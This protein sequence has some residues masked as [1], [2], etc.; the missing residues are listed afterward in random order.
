MRT[1]P[2]EIFPA[3]D[4]RAGRAVRLRQGDSKRETRY[5]EDPVSVACEFEQAGARALHVVDLDGAFAG[6]PAHLA[7]V[8]RICRET[9]LRV[10]LGGG[11][12]GE[13]DLRAAFD[14]GASVAI[15][16]TAAIEES[17]RLIRWTGLFGGSRLAVSIDVRDGAVRT[18]GWKAASRVSLEEA[19]RRVAQAGLADLVVTDVARDGELSGPEL[20]LF[21][22]AALAFGSSVTAAGGISSLED[23]ERLRAEPSVRAVV[24]GR[25][26]YEGTVPLGVLGRRAP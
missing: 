4:L 10:R 17:E 2:F 25:A 18:H 26:L 22:R 16:G 24:V 20:P 13:A 3:L 12:R 9:R 1:E 23:I 14:A 21:R 11:L 15:L 8:E 19:A 7:L 5:S 6:A